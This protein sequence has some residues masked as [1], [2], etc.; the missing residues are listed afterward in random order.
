MDFEPDPDHDTCYQ[1]G[2]FGEHTSS[3]CP[4]LKLLHMSV[5]PFDP[6]RGTDLA[7]DEEG[8]GTST[9]ALAAFYG[10]FQDETGMY[11]RYTRLRISPSANDHNAAS[12][13]LEVSFSKKVNRS[14][15][16]TPLILQSRISSRR[17]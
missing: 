13:H 10:T 7:L 12:Y 3:Q 5:P 14:N 11:C 15:T 16:R 6:S 8:D 17:L 2:A 4:K 9:E 1:C